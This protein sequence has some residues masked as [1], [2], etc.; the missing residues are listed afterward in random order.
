MLDLGSSTAEGTLAAELADAV[1]SAKAAGLR[2]VSDETPGISRRRCGK[3]WCFYGPSGRRITDERILRRIRALAIPPAYTRVWICPDPLGHIQA[4]A[5]DAKGRKQYRYHARWREVR[6][7][8]KF[9]RMIA[10]A[11]ALPSVRARC[12]KDLSRSGIGREKVL[13]AVVRLLEQTR[14]RV[15]NEEYARKN[16]SFGLTT[17]LSRHVAVEGAHMTFSFRGK[18]GKH[19]AVHLHDRRLARV[20]RRCLDIPGQEL[21]TFVDGEGGIHTVSSGDVNDYLREIA[22]DG[23][24][25]KDFRTWSGTVMAAD[26]LRR[27]AV[28]KNKTVARK[29]IKRAIE[30]VSSRLGNTPSVC[31]KSYVHPSVL[32]AYSQNAIGSVPWDPAMREGELHPEERFTLALLRAMAALA[33]VPKPSLEETLAASLAKKAA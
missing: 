13:A 28:A 11:E 23:F 7:A 22:G 31:K 32:D 14:I 29:T 6:D 10:F 24:T 30:Q 4:T 16:R 9:D 15:G 5:R 18:S 1:A 25:A 12:D 27:C 20:V 21:F 33:N 26:E 17:L 8:V 2:Y 3:G 19:H